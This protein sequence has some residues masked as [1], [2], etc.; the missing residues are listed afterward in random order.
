MGVTSA[1][2]SQA[3]LRLLPTEPGARGPPRR[4]ADP[5]LPSS[6][7]APHRR[8]PFARLKYPEHRNATPRPAAAHTSLLGVAKR[9]PHFGSI[10]NAA[11]WAARVL[12]RAQQ[13]ATPVAIIRHACARFLLKHALIAD[14]ASITARNPAHP[15][16]IGA[17]INHRQPSAHE[18]IATAA[19]LLE[20]CIHGRT[21][22][23]PGRRD[24]P[25][26][27]QKRLQPGSLQCSHRR[28]F[29]GPIGDASPAMTS[30]TLGSLP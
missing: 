4:H 10:R 15:A 1:V 12:D 3:A 7:P 2:L 27:G 29:D 26:D 13:M 24:L 25:L 30:A 20:R 16:P 21:A 28:A 11:R 6:H 14:E 9:Q 8:A 19:T 5:G 17:A 23:P 18:D 22:R